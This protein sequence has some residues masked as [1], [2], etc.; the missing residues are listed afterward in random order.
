[1]ASDYGSH[2]PIGTVSIQ[3]PTVN[4]RLQERRWRWLFSK[5]DKAIAIEAK[6]GIQIKNYAFAIRKITNPR[7]VRFI[8]RISNKKIYVFIA[9]KG[10]AKQMTNNYAI[11]EINRLSLQVRQ[12]LNKYKI[13]ILS[14]VYLTISTYTTRNIIAIWICTRLLYNIP[15]SKHDWEKFFTH[16]QFS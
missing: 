4:R 13:I 2:L 10:I 8:S 3:S 15:K 1:M 14:N 5:K 12:L 7:N 6:G 11:I 16:S 9:G